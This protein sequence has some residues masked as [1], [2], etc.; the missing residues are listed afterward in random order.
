MLFGEIL[1]ETNTMLRLA[2]ANL[3]DARA[4]GITGTVELDKRRIRITR[5]DPQAQP[6][7]QW[8]QV[9]VPPSTLALLAKRSPSTCD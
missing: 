2:V 4:F 5:R 9:E 8:D 7:R 6:P 3:G 1:H